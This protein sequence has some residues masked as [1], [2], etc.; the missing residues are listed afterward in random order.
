M[1]GDNNNEFDNKKIAA[2]IA[3]LRAERANIMGY[4]THAH[5]ILEENMLKTP[6][7]VYDLLLQ[8]WRPALKRAKV[9]VADM[10]AVADAEGQ[11]FKV[12][13]WDW[14]H[15]SEKV[16]KAKYDLDEAAIK[17]VRAVKGD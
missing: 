16:R 1:R 14:W 13:A 5:F 4:K 8:L 2:Q 6:E 11:D 15:Y 9:E 3:K 17:I 10:Q 7:E 12:A